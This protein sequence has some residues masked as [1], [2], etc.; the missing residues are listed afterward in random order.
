MHRDITTWEQYISESFELAHLRVSETPFHLPVREHE[1][2]TA[3]RNAEL[4]EEIRAKEVALDDFLERIIFVE[5][6]T[7]GGKRIA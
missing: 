3:E 6:T 2:W 5:E 4:S 7:I 1:H